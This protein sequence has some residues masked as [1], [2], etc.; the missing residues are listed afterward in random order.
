MRQWWSTRK[1]ASCEMTSY[2][3]VKG[4]RCAV[5]GSRLNATAG[6]AGEEWES[7]KEQPEMMGRHSFCNCWVRRKKP[8]LQAREG[9]VD[10]VTGDRK[11]CTGTERWTCSSQA[12]PKE[13]LLGRWPRFSP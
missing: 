8:P 13:R 11:L 10:D 3:R 9:G 7:T 12:A 4:E 1:T 2:G 5:R 6:I